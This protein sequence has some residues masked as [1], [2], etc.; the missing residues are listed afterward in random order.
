[1][2]CHKLACYL[3]RFVCNGTTGIIDV[4][5]SDEDDEDLCVITKITTPANTGAAVDPQVG[6]AKPV[7]VVI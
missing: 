2:F 1:M 4:C 3:T 5:S 6:T 7:T